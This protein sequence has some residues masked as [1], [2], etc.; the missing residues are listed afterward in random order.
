MSMMQD[1]YQQ[2]A[3]EEMDPEELPDVPVEEP[4]HP[5][6]V[7]MTSFEERE[8]EY[9]DG[10]RGAAGALGDLSMF[11]G[12]AGT[13]LGGVELGMH[14]MGA[15]A[16]SLDPKVSASILLGSATV[17]FMGVVASGTADMA[18][19]DARRTYRDMLRYQVTDEDDQDELYS[20]LD[21]AADV[22]QGEPDSTRD[23]LDWMGADPATA[24]DAVLD[25][26]AGEDD[27]VYQEVAFFGR[28]QSQKFGVLTYADG[29]PVHA[30]I[31]QGEIG[32]YSDIGTNIMD[33]REA[34]EALH[35]DQ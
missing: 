30:M 12:A 15:E 3:I 33:D 4:E 8:Q 11:G 1:P 14:N 26:V 29:E 24:Y 7:R 27:D 32:Q 2:E 17:G 35:G 21:D 5:P 13:L 16:M 25:E 22:W 34:Y 18:R 9:E 6:Y 31:G 10:H 20:L 19:D 23:E 28:G